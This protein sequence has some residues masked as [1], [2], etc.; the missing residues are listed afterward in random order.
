M[1]K[2]IFACLFLTSIVA[3]SQTVKLEGT[4]KDSIGNPLELA[5]V[6]ALV[7]GTSKVESYSITNDKGRYRLILPSNVTY[8][9]RISYIGFETFNEE[10]SIADNALDITKDITLKEEGNTLDAVELT[11][12]MPVT[13]KGDTIVYNSDSFTNGTEKKL[14]DILKKLPGVEI[15]EDGQ[16][17]V[18]G[19]Q[20]QKVMVEGKDFFDGDSKL[21]SKNIPANAID[22]IEVLKNYN[23]VGPMRGV[24]DDS[25][26]IAI[27]IRLKEGKK[28]FWFGEITAGVGT[29][30]GYLAHP[31]LFYYSPKTS[32]NIITDVNNIG[33]VPFT[34]RDYFKF[35][36]GFRNMMR[37]GGTSFNI[38]SNGLGFSMTQNNMAKDIVS[39]FG[40]FN[41][42]YSPK[43]SLTFS[44]FSILNDSETELFTE[45]NINNIVTSTVEDRTTSTLQRTKLAMLKLSANYVP[46]ESTHFDY[47]VF[48]KKSKET[49][50]EN[51]NSIISLNFEDIENRKTQKPSSINQNLNYYKVVDDKNIFSVEMQH[52]YQNE[53]PLLNLVRSSQPFETV[54]PTSQENLY[55]LSQQKDISTNKFDGKVDYYYIL[56]KKS[57][58]NFTLGS[59]LSKQNFDSNIFQILDDNS[60]L[61]FADVTLNNDVTYNFS[62]VFLG[63]HYKAVSGKFTFT[64]GFS[65]HSYTTKDQQL[66][67]TNKNSDFNIV[68]DLSIQ[69]KLKQSENIRF[70]YSMSREYTDV[71]KL[72]E[73]YIFNNFNSL[74]EGNRNLESALYNTF[75]LSYFSFSMFNFTN[76]NASINY[77]K[78]TN[79]IKSRTNFIGL[80]QT[81]SEPFN[82]NLADE[83]WSARGRYGR[84]FGKFKINARANFGFSKFN[85]FVN[86]QPNIS[87]SFTQTYT[88]SIATNFKKAPNLE[89]G[90][91]KIFNDYKSSLNDNKYT[92]D[93]PFAKLDIV[94]LKDFSFVT[95]YSYYNYKD[96]NNSVKNTYSFLDTSLYYQKKDSK[97]EFIISG[98]NLTDNASINRDNFSE[99]STSSSSYF[100]QPKRYMFTVKYNL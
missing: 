13:I 31:K 98:K 90:Y 4:I 32:I 24:G 16:I 47:D 59:T 53:N 5:N 41:F 85:G 89:I 100:V 49:E 71:N 52:L 3:F 79:D 6:I 56:N 10:V 21:A 23:E 63:L 66:G 25:D 9:L 28:N 65:V 50:Y 15:N 64:P 95:D 70:N 68:P 11:F 81:S 45:N 69:V 2:I 8:S 54:I 39:R 42:S 12:E 73:G 75:S 74:S 67:T 86:N 99:N 33:E 27:N 55:D 78:K 92:T 14:E 80:N 34:F 19:K 82:S 48:I 36:G 17:E 60:Q 30:D 72:A 22:K 57:N 76:I 38:S 91:T 93:K 7:K 96:D 87:E 29:E 94:F 18:E 58:L 62:D 51:I 20:V 26:N 46:N 88:G 83:T 37:K 40:A 61:D 84:R 77:S 43:K 1:K 44:G 35:T 97:W